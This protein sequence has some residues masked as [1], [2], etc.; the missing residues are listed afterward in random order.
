MIR[1]EWNLRWWSWEKKC[2]RKEK[3]GTQ[4]SHML[5]INPYND[6]NM[7]PVKMTLI[8][9]PYMY[10]VKFVVYC[11]LYYSNNINL[12]LVLIYFHIVHL[13]LSLDLRMIMFAQ[14]TCLVYYIEWYVSLYKDYLTDEGIGLFPVQ[15]TFHPSHPSRLFRYWRQPYFIAT[16]VCFTFPFNIYNVFTYHTFY[17]YLHTF[18]FSGMYMAWCLPLYH[19][20]IYCWALSIYNYFNL[21]PMPL[22]HSHTL[23][24]YANNQIRLNYLDMLDAKYKN[25]YM[26]G[27]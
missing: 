26:N 14:P 7:Y 20:P 13:F 11:I 21:I 6:P 2:S 12:F 19:N 24:S 17:Y 3:M 1:R 16:M 22:Y 15:Q 27:I 25:V 9:I 4:H 18:S 10:I 23:L 5:I 8:F